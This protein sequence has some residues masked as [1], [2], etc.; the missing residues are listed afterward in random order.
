[1]Y[2]GEMR[3]ILNDKSLLKKPIVQL[4]LY[5]CIWS[6]TERRSIMALVDMAKNCDEPLDYIDKDQTV[7]ATYGPS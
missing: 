3:M 6:A 5:T 1:M 4:Y 7:I 2:G